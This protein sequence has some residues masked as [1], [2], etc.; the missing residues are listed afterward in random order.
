MVQQ[1]VRDD[2]VHVH[3]ERGVAGGGE[4]VEQRRHVR[5]VSARAA[6]LLGY[7]GAQ[8]A[9]SAGLGPQFAVDMLLFGEPFLMRDDLGFDE[10]AQRVA[11]DLEIR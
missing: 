3:A 7:V 10:P 4:L 1:V 11:V 8:H 2:D 5:E 6:V 9:E